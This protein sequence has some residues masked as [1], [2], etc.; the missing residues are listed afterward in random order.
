[1]TPQGTSHSPPPLPSLMPFPCSS[2]HPPQVGATRP[3]TSPARVL[4]ILWLHAR[5]PPARAA[6]CTQH[7]N[8]RLGSSPRPRMPQ[9]P[10]HVGATRPLTSR[11]RSSTASGC[12]QPSSAQRASRASA[13]A[14]CSACVSCLTCASSAACS[15]SAWSCGQVCA[16]VCACA[17]VCVR[18]RVRVC[19]CVCV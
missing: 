13:S 7:L 2:Q 17:R 15:R 3:L 6:P 18:V 19:A 4:H 1:M 10:L 8:K 5:S 14:C 12:T 11:R 9:R 16:C